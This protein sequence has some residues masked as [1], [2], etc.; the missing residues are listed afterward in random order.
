MRVRKTAVS[1]TRAAIVVG[2]LVI[3]AGAAIYLYNSAPPTSTS[4]SGSS[5]STFTSPS[6]STSFSSSSST[7]SSTT[8][9]K[10]AVLTYETPATP[11][12][13]DPGVSYFSYDFIIFQQVYESLLW[14]NGTVSGAVIPW[15]AQ[16]YAASADAKTYTFTLR[17]GLTFA[18]GEPVNSTSVYFSLN[19]LLV[20]DA[21]TP[22]SHGTQGGW[23]IQQLLNTTLST[24]Q[25]GA[26]QHY[27][28]AY[29]QKVLAENFVQVTGPY[30]F[31]IHV[32]HPNAAFPF[33]MAGE[34]AAILAPKYVMQRD[35]QL[36]T[37]SSNGYTLPFST[38]SGS[39]NNQITQ[40]LEDWS[41][42][43]DSGVTKGGCATT[44]LDGS[45]SGS[46][47]GTGPYTITS[48]D[49]NTN[50]F[51]LAANPSFWGGPTGKIHPSIKTVNIN[52]VGDINT[53]ELDLQNAARSGQAMAIDPDT[54]HLYDLA[55]RTAWLRNNVLKS[56][57]TGVNLYGTYSALTTL[58]DPFDT[59]VTSALT[60]SFYSFQ[61]FADRRIRLAFAD[62]VNITDIM[63][64]VNNK[65]GQ[66]AINVV[67]PG[68]PPGGSFFPN[69]KPVY[70]FNLLAAQ[71][72]LLDAMQHPVTS[73]TYTNGTAVKPGVF[74]N[75][76]GCATL[77]SGK[78]ANPVGQNIQLVFGI[79]DSTDEAIF[80]T[81]AGNI[82]NI[83]STYNMGLT[84]SVTPLPTGTLLNE[85]FSTPTHLYC[86]ALGWF[87]DYPWVVDFAGPMYAPLNTYPGPD[88]W[89]LGAMATLWQ[90]VQT[91]SAANNIQGLNSDVHQ[92]NLIANNAVMY[93]WTQYPLNFMAMTSNVGGFYF[94][95]ALSTSAAGGTGPEYFATLFTT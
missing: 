53:R 7:S 33:L 51:V 59:N 56:T 13:L 43:C 62:A 85:A 21:S 32:T 47:A 6:S 72:L 67:A 16:S 28:L 74:N 24:Q 64:T 95:P 8:R 14:Y 84:V 36:W 54:A 29:A 82:N 60:G 11:Q 34:W 12:Y 35:M 27:G 42:T 5:T 86:Y 41:A 63:N 19:R 39:L 87:A 73:F 20:G 25:S 75:A 78:C 79:G 69:D 48:Y 77:T 46:K 93:L 44:Y 26:A 52:Y 81:I 40:Y 80:N 71:N 18:D 91:D 22:T 70:S 94:N 50:D 37:Q 92:M 90:K 1:T 57:V 3:A 61:P 66:T 55:N 4:S 31:T 30:T 83:S 68:L 89:N 76:F 65:L 49:K 38:L 15:L 45:Y 2:I 10:P 23:I 58:F 17:Q 88:G 9:A